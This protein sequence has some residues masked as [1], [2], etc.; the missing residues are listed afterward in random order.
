MSNFAW[1][2]ALVLTLTALGSG[3]LL[4]ITLKY[5][6]GERGTPPPTGEERKRLHEEEL[7][8][9]AKQIEHSRKNKWE[10]RSEN[11]FDNTKG[12]TRR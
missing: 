3:T 12:S 11:F 4:F 7:Q 6:W 9:R 8:L 1:I 5:Y 10:T 2:I